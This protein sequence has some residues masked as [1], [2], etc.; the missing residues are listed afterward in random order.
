MRDICRVKSKVI[1]ASPIAVP[2][3]A[4]A[5]LT[6]RGLFGND[7]P[8]ELEIGVGKAGFLLRRAKALPERNF[9]GI[10]WAGK[11][12]RY[13]VDRLMRHGVTNAR[14]VRTD[15]S[16]FVRVVC[17]RGSLAALHIY[18][19]DPWPKARHHR[20]RLIQR[21]F[22]DAAAACLAP[23][24]RWAVQTDHA[25][26]FEQIRALLIGHPAL[27]ETEFEDSGWGVV[28][29]RL[30]TNFEIKYRREGRTIYRIAVLRSAP[31]D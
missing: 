13:A 28:E 20:R 18:H 25:E 31:A 30:D 6:W 16:Y 9:L 23:G 15:A 12:Y 2:A 24:G 26:Y 3:E 11:Y 19:P 8:V 14:L 5:S 4:L 22:V 17:P 27:V 29:A 7:H 10:E 21:D 1:E